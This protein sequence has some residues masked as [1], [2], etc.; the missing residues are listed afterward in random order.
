MMEPIAGSKDKTKNMLPPGMYL[1]EQLPET[2]DD[3][4]IEK[5]T[6]ETKNE[7]ETENKP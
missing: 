7:E 1:D 6:R 5:L 3:K 2:W 4:D